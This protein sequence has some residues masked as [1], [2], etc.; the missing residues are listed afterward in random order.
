VDIDNEEVI[1]LLERTAHIAD[2][3]EG[4]VD[5]NI[6]ISCLLKHLPEDLGL[7]DG[8]GELAV[9]E[10]QQELL[11]VRY[12]CWLH[13]CCGSSAIVDGPQTGTKT[14]VGLCL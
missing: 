13:E 10:H 5:I 7:T 3:L 1:N 14:L 8:P 6:G 2:A 4:E 11:F 9:F 12:G